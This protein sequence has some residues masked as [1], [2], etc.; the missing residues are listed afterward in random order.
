MVS[1]P[2]IF[3]YRGLYFGIY[4]YTKDV[5]LDKDA[6][7]GIKFAFAQVAVMLS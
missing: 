4:D 6:G 1:I 5:V 7:F 3:I 2:S